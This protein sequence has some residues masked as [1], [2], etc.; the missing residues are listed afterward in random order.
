MDANALEALFLP[1]LS[2]DQPAPAD[3]TAERPVMVPLDGSPLAENALP[4]AVLLAKKW[5]APLLLA[6]AVERH[7]PGDWNS[8]RAAAATL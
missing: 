6:R 1:G 3:S 2:V 7:Y 8:D 4:W 5:N